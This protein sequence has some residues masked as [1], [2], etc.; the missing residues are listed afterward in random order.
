MLQ[1]IEFKLPGSADP[2][3]VKSRGLTILNDPWLNKGTSFTAEERI[4]L[5]EAYAKEQGMW[6]SKDTPDPVFTDTLELDLTSV[7]PSIA[8]EALI[9]KKLNGETFKT[10]AR[11]AVNELKLAD[12][13]AR[14][15]HHA[16]VSTHKK[17]KK[18]D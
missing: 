2:L 3:R 5:V 12:F 8:A 9:R 4:A 16:I 10:G 6:R 11:T 1:K 18:N 7:I 15:A 14:F 13:E 17:G